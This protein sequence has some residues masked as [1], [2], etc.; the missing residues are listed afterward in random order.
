M[1]IR[2]VGIRASVSEVCDLVCTT[3]GVLGVLA[4][5][6]LPEGRPC[7]SL[8]WTPVTSQTSPQLRPFL[9]TLP[10]THTRLVPLRVSTNDAAEVVRPT[11]VVIGLLPL[12]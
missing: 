6:V 9:S 10:R 1:R 3:V 4:A 8:P 11:D 7:V 5:D 12:P 2:L